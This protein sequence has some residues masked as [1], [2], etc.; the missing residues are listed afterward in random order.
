MASAE[1]GV[2]EDAAKECRACE[3]Q[4]GLIEGFDKG[5]NQKIGVIKGSGE[6]SR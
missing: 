3:M 5:R 1:K 4:V 6:K 2:K